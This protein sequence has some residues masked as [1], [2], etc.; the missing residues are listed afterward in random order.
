MRF[1]TFEKNGQ[2]GVGSLVPDENTLLDLTQAGLEGDLISV[3]EKGPAG[4]QLAAS[5]L[6]FKMEIH[7]GKCC[8]GALALSP[9]SWPAKRSAAL[10]RKG[11]LQSKASSQVPL[12]EAISRLS[13]VSKS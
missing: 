12:V 9:G 5:R 4:L 1:V 13:P 7:D 6:G 2:T 10:C 3:I 8:R 11:K